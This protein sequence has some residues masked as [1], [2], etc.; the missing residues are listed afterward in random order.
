MSTNYYHHTSFTFACVH[1]DYNTL[2]FVVH[3]CLSSVLVCVKWK[4]DDNFHMP[5]ICRRGHLQYCIVVTDIL[6]YDVA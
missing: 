2:C 3:S 5:Y 4:I 6:I 1:S